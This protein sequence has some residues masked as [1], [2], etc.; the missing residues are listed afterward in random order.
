MN[1]KRMEVTG[2]TKE[3]ALELAP[4]GI[5]GDATSAYRNARKNHV[6]VWTDA[7]MKQF[8]L[9]YL[10]SKSKNIPGVGFSITL[11]AA[12]K[13]TRKNPWYFKNV[14]NE[15]G[16]R[17]FQMTFNIYENLGTD[18]KPVKGKFLGKCNETKAKSR[19][20]AKKIIS[21][22]FRGRF[23]AEIAHEV[24]EGEPIAWVGGYQPSENAR[25]GRY[26]VFGVTNE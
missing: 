8:M 26:V 9:N 25:F 6:G 14:K 17:K 24:K 20:V 22:G 2:A 13:S 15:K 12:V 5:Q 1:F 18:E 21:D 11:E 16:A 7:D 3:E 4:F 23:Y 10:A 19:E